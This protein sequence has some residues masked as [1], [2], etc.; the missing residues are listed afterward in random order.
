MTG[1]N[2]GSD[3]YISIEGVIGTTGADSFTGLTGENNIFD[4]NAGLDIVDYSTYGGTNGIVV[5]L[6]AAT[7]ANVTV[8]G[9][10]D[11]DI[12]RNIENVIGTAAAD[13]ITGDGLANVLTGNGGADVLNGGGGNDTIN[14]GADADI[15]DGGAG[16]DVINA[17]TGD[18]TINVSTN[19]GV[20]DVIDGEGGVDTIDYSALAQ[21]VEVALNT[22]IATNVTVA[23]AN[24]DNIVNIEN[25]IGSSVNDTITGDSVA[26]ILS[27]LAGADVLSGLG[28]NDTITGGTGAD[29]IDGGTGL[30]TIDGGNDDDLV[31]VTTNDGVIDVID[32]GAGIDTID[33]SALAESIIVDLD[34]AVGVN[35]SVGGATGDNIQNVENVT[36]SS[37]ADIITGDTLTNVLRGMDGNDSLDG[38]AGNDTLYGGNNNDTLDGG[39]GNDA[40]FGEAG[41][42]LFLAGTGIDTYD[43]GVG[44]SDT[45]DFSGVSGNINLDLTNETATKIG[46]SSNQDN[47]TEI[48]NLILGAG[49][50]GFVMD[51]ADLANFTAIDGGAGLDTLTFN[52]TSMDLD[53]FGGDGFDGSDI[54]GVFSDI[55]ELDFT[56]ITSTGGSFELTGQELKDVLGADNTDN[57]TIQMD[58]G[59][60]FSFAN[61]TGLTFSGTVGSTSTY[62]YNDGGTIYTVDVIDNV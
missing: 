25:V 51:A 26:N 47:F 52:T 60:G 11:E 7:D 37:V 40:L 30:D 17:G 29:T 13:T 55:E 50:D 46:D 35:V 19:D 24:A 16:L 2:L 61:G 8:D 39:S 62:E 5:T 34:G 4:G 33:Y 42:D 10:A 9:A 58:S 44:G 21:S 48:E 59:T 18:D 20:I 31:N 23:G 49:A 43:G 14:A 15:I 3:T 28:G 32:G 45:I 53:T 22:N 12:I 38:D 1:T 41:D 57:L 6:N 56:N 36:G 54:A 27:G